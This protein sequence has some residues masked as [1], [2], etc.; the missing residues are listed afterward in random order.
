VYL[1]SGTLALLEPSEEKTEEIETL[2]RILSNAGEEALWS[3]TFQPPVENMEVLSGF[4][5]VRLYYTN[6]KPAFSRSHRGID[7][8]GALGD[9]VLAPNSGVV[10]FS[11][12]RITTGNTIVID[13]GQGVFSLFFHLDTL[14][15]EPG[16]LVA[17]GQRI[18]EIGMT[19]I[20]EG[21][22]LHWGMFVNGVYI[23]PLD[24]LKLAF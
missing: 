6:G 19:G 14:Y 2:F 17:K 5:K 12:M 18:G 23:N 7:L 24:W 11:G 3:F 16:T 21:A 1:T 4:G 9:Y 15:V 22:H 10:V 13:H 20:A 8:K